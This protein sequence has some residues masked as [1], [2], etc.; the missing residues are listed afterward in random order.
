LNADAEA[1]A[2]RE[3][4]LQVLCPAVVTV[5]HPACKSVELMQAELTDEKVR[6]DALFVEAQ[7]LQ[8]TVDALQVS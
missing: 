5:V 6:A 2:A 4:G 1:A 7:A 3:A 8:A